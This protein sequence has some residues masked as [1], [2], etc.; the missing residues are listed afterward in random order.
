MIP[1]EILSKVE[2][3]RTW[4]G[5]KRRDDRRNSHR[6]TDKGKGSTEV[7]VKHLDDKVARTVEIV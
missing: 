3:I 5:I 6:F 1:P 4:A 7:E 2:S